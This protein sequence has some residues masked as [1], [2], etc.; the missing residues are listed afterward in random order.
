[1][2]GCYPN[3]DMRIDF[4]SLPVRW[5]D[6]SATQRD[7]FIDVAWQTRSEVNNDYFK[8][9]RSTDGQSFEALGEV[10]AVG[11]SNSA[12][13]YAFVDHHPEPGW[14]QYRIRQID[15]NGNSETSKVVTVNYV[16]PSRL[17][18]AGI[19]PHPFVDEVRIAYLSDRI[20]VVD[21]QL[22]DGRGHL[23]M[24]QDW[25]SMTGMNE[26]RLSLGTLPAGVYLLRLS[27]GGTVVNHKLVKL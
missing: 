5:G 13:T 19:G 17:D 7:F 18:F 22:Y 11:Q 24:R 26:V 14:N 10:E 25:K 16:P 4:T 15:Q 3:P 27:A 20:Q 12:Q 23:V 9:E 8:V 2:A 1:M 21:F 6:I